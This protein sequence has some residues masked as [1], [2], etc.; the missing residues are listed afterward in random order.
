MVTSDAFTYN[1]PAGGGN[2]LLVVLLAFGYQPTGLSAT[3]NGTSLSCQQF[4]GSIIRAYHYYCYL[5]APTSGTFSVSWSGSSWFEY[6]VFTL[7]NAAQSSPIDAASVSDLTSSGSSLSTSVTT[8][9][10]NDL[11]LDNFVGCASDITITDGAGQ[12]RLFTGNVAGFDPYSQ[13]SKAAASVAGTETMSRN[14]SPND[15]NDDLAVIAVKQLSAS[16]SVQV[17]STTPYRQ[18]FTYDALGNML[19]ITNGATSSPIAT[20][21]LLASSAERAPGQ[22]TSDSFAFDSGSTG[23]NRMLAFAYV[24]A[25]GG[26]PTSAT[27]NGQSLTIRTFSINQYYVSWG[28]LLNPPTGSHTFTINYPN[29]NVPV[30]RVFVFQD[31]K[32]DH[33]V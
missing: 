11:L 30:Y 4:T 7:Q 19:S 15:Y 9:Q 18:F 21:S 10:G 27:Y 28:Y 26:E 31:V 22:S 6:S 25:N 16:T 3:Q 24:S 8:T 5:P 1:V 2:K 17:A 13:T 20:P 32:P 23:S 33:A 12:T 29:D 14:F